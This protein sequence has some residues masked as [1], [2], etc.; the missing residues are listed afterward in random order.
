MK[1]TNLNE[2]SDPEAISPHKFADVIST[3]TSYNKPGLPKPPGGWNV[4]GSTG[5]MPGGVC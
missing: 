1:I 4:K 3:E 2:M 5:P